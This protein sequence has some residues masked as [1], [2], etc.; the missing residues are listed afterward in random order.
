[1]FNQTYEQRLSAWNKFR[2][3][4]ED[5]TDPIK[6]VMEF[7]AKTPTVSIAT[8]P[9][10]KSMWPSPWELILENQYDEFCIVLGM[11][12]SLQLTDRFKGSTLEIHIGI[13]KDK[14]RTYYLLKV[15][16]YILDRYE[17]YSKTGHLPTGFMPQ[18]VHSFSNHNK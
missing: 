9:Y 17:I 16:N 4:L 6:D 12:Y 8:D 10:D 18:M 7:Y 5:S 11:C 15:E 14:S 2:K 13:D 3:N 1:M